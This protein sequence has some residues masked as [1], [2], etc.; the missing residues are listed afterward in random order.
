M[1]FDTLRA[2][3][4]AGAAAL[5]VAIASV[6]HA[7]DYTPVR[8]EVP[9]V[10]VGKPLHSPPTSSDLEAGGAL[11]GSLDPVTASRLEAAFEKAFGAAKAHAMTA[12]VGVP[13]Q[14]V[15]TRNQGGAAPLY[16]WASVGK[17]ATAVVVLQL[18]DEGRLRLSD[19][20]E[21]WV[22]G[23]PNGAVI[24]L[25]DLLSHT[26]GLFSANEDLQAHRLNR[27]LDTGAEL[28][29]LRRHGAMFCPG[30]RW[31][32]SNSGYAL[33]G[34]VIERIDQRSVAEAIT[35]RIIVPLGLTQM[36]ALTS[37]TGVQDVVP[38]HSDSAE[39]SINVTTPGPAGP[40]AASAMD[41]LR[42]EQ[43][44]LDG[45]LL[46]AETRTR[47][48]RDLYPMFDDNT[49]YGLGVMLYDVPGVSQ[50]LYWIGHSGGAPGVKAV[51][52]YA[53]HQHAFVAVALTGDGSA[54][55]VAN[56]MLKALAEP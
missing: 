33:L 52:A 44:I 12:A 8:C 23:V 9:K 32:Y 34:Q 18:A 25:Q 7:A 4:R 39:P 42:F 21:R 55:A 49:Y 2:R 29:I 11:V 22:H 35:A 47:M 37:S 48:L 56:L 26:S 41:M 3:F 14:G 31:R 54:E 40:L 17:Q 50:R 30:E 24:T 28:A 45:H 53:P 13:G 6:A 16:Y 27:R 46:R 19:P 36:R 1:R 38:P 10:Y 51:S 20:I 15:W 43:A 5:G